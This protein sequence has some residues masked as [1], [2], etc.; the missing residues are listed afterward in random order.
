MNEP[1][2]IIEQIVCRFKLIYPHFL[3]QNTFLTLLMTTLKFPSSLHQS[4]Y[5]F[6]L[7][8]CQSFRHRSSHLKS[9]GP[10][11]T[12]KAFNN[13]QIFN[14]SRS[15]EPWVQVRRSSQ[16]SRTQRTFLCSTQIFLFG[17][18]DHSLL[19]D[20]RLH[21]TPYYVE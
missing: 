5:L 17:G 2:F 18:P 19:D 16:T 13:R 3:C 15:S 11:G 20:R 14:F 4:P 1:F 10:S 12:V 21:R 7:L 8:I 6:L 9:E